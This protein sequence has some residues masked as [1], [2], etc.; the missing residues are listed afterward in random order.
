MSL[1]GGSLLKRGHGRKI[2]T[3]FLISFSH[4]Q[5]KI[6]VISYWYC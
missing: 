5:S 4:A 2:S 6:K 1:Q 3:L